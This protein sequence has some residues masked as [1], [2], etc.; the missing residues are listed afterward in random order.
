M[1]NYSHKELL[2]EPIMWCFWNTVKGK[3][4]TGLE[5]MTGLGPRLLKYYP[6]KVSL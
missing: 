5:C 2:L 6:R 1:N 4:K 3:K